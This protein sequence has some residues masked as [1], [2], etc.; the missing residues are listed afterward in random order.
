VL[1]L[2]PSLSKLSRDTFLQVTDVISAKETKEDVLVLIR[3]LLSPSSNVRA[4]VL[5]SLEPF[6][7]EDT[8]N[9]EILFLATQ[10]LEE[11]NSE[12]AGAL[13]E[14]NSLSLDSVALS[15]LFALLGTF[16]S[17]DG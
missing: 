4:A 7:L 2:I 16:S 17:D 15:R 1:L 8:D 6:D 14:A 11:R 9:P 12:L 3:G 13:Y 5:Q 10:D